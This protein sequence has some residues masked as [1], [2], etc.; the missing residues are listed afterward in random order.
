MAPSA[1]D[2]S[3]S[4]GR[5]QSRGR[6]R[7][8]CRSSERDCAFVICLI[9]NRCPL[10]SVDPRA[11]VQTRVRAHFQNIVA[12]IREKDELLLTVTEY[13][14][15]AKNFAANYRSLQRSIGASLHR[16]DDD[17]AWA[18]QDQCMYPQTKYDSQ[19]R[20]RWDATTRQ[21]LKEDIASGKR[22]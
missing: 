9:A 13:K 20:P 10:R 8:K 4:G 15:Y 22:I 5:S 11:L 12:L 21:L 14:P 3:G 1:T 19:G 16:R 6:E 18:V 2:T 17:H 7:F